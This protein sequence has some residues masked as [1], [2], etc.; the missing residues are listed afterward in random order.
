MNYPDDT[1]AAISTPVGQG[2]IGIVRL[3]GPEAVEIADRIFRSKNNE[4]PSDA[5]SRKMLYGHI[6][7]PA[8]ERVVD[9]VLLA[10]MPAP[11][12]YTREDVVEINCHG[13]LVSVRQI[14]EIALRQG[15]RIAEPGE[16]TKRAFLHGRIDLSQAEAV[17]DI[18]NAK[19][20]ESMRIACE[21]LRGGL[22]EKLSEIREQLI[23][24]TAFVEAHIDFP[25]DE[26]EAIPK[27]EIENKLSD[28]SAEIRRLSDTFNEAR[29]FREGLSIAIVGRPNVGKSSLL[30]ALLQK[31]RAIVTDLPGTTRDLIEDYLNINGLPIRIMDTAGIR[32]SDETIEQEGIR[33]SIQAIEH[34]DFIVAMFDGSEPFGQEDHDLLG[35]IRDKNAV[36]VI[37]KADLPQRISLENSAAERKQ[38]LC[39]SAVTGEGIESLKSVIFESNLHGWKE[40]REGVVVTNIRHKAALDS[41]AESLSR[42]GSLLSGNNPLELFSIEMRSSLD[43][44]GEIAGTITTDEIL[45]KIFSSFCIGK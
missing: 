22:T 21:Q 3:S 45:L 13:S 42:A 38:C 35:I 19:T 6:V 15:V 9:E 34:A 25:E 27:K 24:I 26:I 30:N 29:F 37:S 33:R 17:L 41:A 40:E 12:S 2:G 14:L 36:M 4:K 5:P 31:D 18:I 7:D 20:E 32:S 44:I 10:I 28:V 8:D 43:R 23:E 1:I 16:F 39:L 11:N